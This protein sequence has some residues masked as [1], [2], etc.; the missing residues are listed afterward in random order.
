MSPG[1]YGDI[2]PNTMPISV[3]LK[4]QFADWARVFDET[5]NMSD[6]ASSG[7]KSA[8][9]ETAFKAKGVELAAQLQKELGGDFLVSV[10]V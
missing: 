4:R 10:K 7:F 5:L 8:E 9:A 1:M 2:D 6:P 3:E